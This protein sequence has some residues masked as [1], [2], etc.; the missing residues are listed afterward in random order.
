MNCNVLRDWI[1]PYAGTCRCNCGKD[2]TRVPCTVAERRKYK[3]YGC[4]NSEN[5]E[6]DCCA[7]A[8]MCECGTRIVGTA[9]GS[10]EQ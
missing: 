9:D 6:Y 7:R 5:D 4:W 2:A 3:H 10:G 1:H 8:F